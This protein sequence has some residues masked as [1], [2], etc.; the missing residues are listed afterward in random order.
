M[1]DYIMDKISELHIDEVFIST[2]LKF[3]TDFEN[4]LRSRKGPMTRIVAD[5]ALREEEKPGAAAALAEISPLVKDDCLIIAGDN[6]FT[7]SLTG[8][9]AVHRKQEA[10]TIGLYDVRDKNLARQYSTVRVDSNGRIIEF[11]EK[12]ANPQSTLIGTCIY[13]LPQKT[14]PRLREFNSENGDHDSPG[15]FIQW[16]YQRE[17]VYGAPMSGDWWDIG[18]LQQYARV[19][20]LMDTSRT[21][22]D[23]VKPR[24]ESSAE[25]SKS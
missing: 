1:I 20:E 9:A 7:S 22:S 12:P 25:M 24:Q 11:Q 23:V 2:N 10:A 3:K 16:L 18:T 5:L 6:L 4:W 13:F 21:D 15:R 14:V 19:N 17:P 8:L